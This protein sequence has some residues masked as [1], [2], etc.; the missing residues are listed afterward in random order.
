MRNGR[1]FKARFAADET[2]SL[3]LTKHEKLKNEAFDTD[4]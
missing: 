3:S 1:I 4:W 2:L